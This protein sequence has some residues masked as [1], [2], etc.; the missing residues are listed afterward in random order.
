LA[1]VYES[2][3]DSVRSRRAYERCAEGIDRQLELY[4]DDARAMQFGASANAFL[5][6]RERAFALIDRSLTL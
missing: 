1:Q 2:L 6:R 3:G 5:G 4:P